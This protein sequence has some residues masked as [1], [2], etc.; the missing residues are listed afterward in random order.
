MNFLRGEL[1]YNAITDEERE[2]QRQ[3]ELSRI[4]VNPPPVANDVRPVGEVPYYVGSQALLF[5]VRIA[6]L[7]G[8][9]YALLGSNQQNPLGQSG[10]TGKKPS[11]P[12]KP[13]KPKRRCV[14]Y[15]DS[16]PASTDTTRSKTI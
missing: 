12:S 3:R 13:S 15:S 9:A 7:A 5:L 2:T 8:A 14:Q 11:K 10:K 6:I 1:T 4:G 16:Q